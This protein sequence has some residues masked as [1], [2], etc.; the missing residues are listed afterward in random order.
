MS[1]PSSTLVPSED[2][3]QHATALGDWLEPWRSAVALG[4][5]HLEKMS[6]LY[7]PRQLR[8]WWLADLRQLTGD[9]LRSPEF[10]ALM[11]FNLTLLARR[12]TPSAF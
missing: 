4:C 7:D 6:A 3:G 5:E 1:G 10:L 9:S 11:K 2:R 8:A 12:K